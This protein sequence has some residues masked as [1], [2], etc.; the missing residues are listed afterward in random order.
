M[1]GNQGSQQGRVVGLFLCGHDQ[2]LA[3]EESHADVLKGGVKRDGGHA[4]Y[5]PGVGQYGMGKNIGRM[6]VKVV[7]YALVAQHDAFGAACAAAGV[8]EVGQVVGRDVQ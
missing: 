3:I 1:A 7:A 8:N 4:Q 2:S 6:S 5:A